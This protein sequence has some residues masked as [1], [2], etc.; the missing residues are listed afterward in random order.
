MKYLWTF[1]LKGSTK[2]IYNWSTD[3]VPNLY[4]KEIR[5]TGPGVTK[6]VKGRVL[7]ARDEL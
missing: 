3:M 2:S 7:R 4:V 5:K 6:T 1:L